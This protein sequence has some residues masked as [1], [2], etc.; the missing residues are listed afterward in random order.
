MDYK[1]SMKLLILVS[2][3]AIFSCSNSSSDEVRYFNDNLKSFDSIR[4]FLEKKYSMRL[5]DLGENRPRIKF[6]DCEK[7]GRLSNEDYVCDEIKVIKWM[8]KNDLREISFEYPKSNCSESVHFKELVF[9]R[10]T[11]LLNRGISIVYEYC[12][13]SPPSKTRTFEYIPIDLHWSIQIDRN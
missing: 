1:I 4:I 2:I 11:S 12:G 5:L 3:V 13:T 10:R 8:E 9:L 7:E 6:V